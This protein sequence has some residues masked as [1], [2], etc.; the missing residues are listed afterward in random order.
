[1]LSFL[2]RC[3]GFSSGGMDHVFPGRDRGCGVGHSGVDDRIA[4]DACESVFVSQRSLAGNPADL[5][6]SAVRASR[7]IHGCQGE[8]IGWIL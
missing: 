1:M 7:D 3:L 5:L 4:E 8:M 2:V 6:L